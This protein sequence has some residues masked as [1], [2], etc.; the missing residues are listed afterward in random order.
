MRVVVDVEGVQSAT[1]ELPERAIV[2][3]FPA[4]CA[5]LHYTRG[6]TPDVPPPHAPY[7]RTNTEMYFNGNSIG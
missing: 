6:K 1:E 2:E 4:V 3:H 5:K 7:T